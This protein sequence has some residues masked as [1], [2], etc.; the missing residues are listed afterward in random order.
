[1]KEN[2]KATLAAIDNR[3][4]TCRNQEQKAKFAAIEQFQE[5]ESE[6][7][8]Q[9]IGIKLFAKVLANECEEEFHLALESKFHFEQE[10]L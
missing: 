3:Y 7:Q 5:P 1:M 2:L 8:E 9:D 4:N 10:A 6:F